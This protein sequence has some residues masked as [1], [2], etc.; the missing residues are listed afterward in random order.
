MSRVA[1]L[2]GE[3]RR[4]AALLANPDT[5]SAQREALVDLDAEVRAA[6]A[7]ASIDDQRRALVA[8]VTAARA[9]GD[10][11]VRVHPASHVGA[12]PPPGT[13]TMTR[14][15]VEAHGSGAVWHVDV[16][17]PIPSWWP[18]TG[19]IDSTSPAELATA[20]AAREVELRAAAAADQA[21]ARALHGIAPG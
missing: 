21:S 15:E 19:R 20:R 10:E 2:Q 1:D 11:T 7:E 3:A 4:I 18:R 8:R 16:G 12:C 5:T 14:A 6:I 13:M 9:A 17:E